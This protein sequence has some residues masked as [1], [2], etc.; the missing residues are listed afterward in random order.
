MATFYEGRDAGLEAAAAYLEKTA[1]D[2]QQMLEVVR[3]DKTRTKEQKRH[4]MHRYQDQVNLLRG[5]ARL[6]RQLK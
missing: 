1:E 5:Q 6:I 3:K 4:E 2:Y